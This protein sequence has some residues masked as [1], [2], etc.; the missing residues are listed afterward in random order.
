MEKYTFDSFTT[1]AQDV[2]TPLDL[3][4]MKTS[5]SLKLLD[6]NDDYPSI[7]FPTLVA[8][9]VDPQFLPPWPDTRLIQ[10]DC[11]MELDYPIETLDQSI[12][13]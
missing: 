5:H 9:E 8:F 13:Y 6:A 4:N 12:F 3:D 2:Y 10:D 1:C 7:I 11:I